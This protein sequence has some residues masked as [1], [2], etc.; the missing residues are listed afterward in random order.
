MN[1][2]LFVTAFRNVQKLCQ[3]LNDDIV[4]A[5]QNITAKLRPIKLLS[6]GRQ[7]ADG[8]VLWPNRPPLADITPTQAA[9]ER[10][11]TLQ[12]DLSQGHK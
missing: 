3:D 12:S 1:L 4:I 7:M 6:V 2:Q 11:V 5:L 10:P 8:Q 9:L